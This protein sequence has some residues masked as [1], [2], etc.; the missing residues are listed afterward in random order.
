MFS[1]FSFMYFEMISAIDSIVSSI[2]GIGVLSDRIWLLAMDPVLWSLLRLWWSIH[3]TCQTQSICLC[4]QF[5]MTEQGDEGH[6][7]SY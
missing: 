1:N 6:I 5:G 3:S 2:Y 4:L 7:S